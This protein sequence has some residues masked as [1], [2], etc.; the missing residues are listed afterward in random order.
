MAGGG[1]GAGR[2]DGAEGVD[3]CL[4]F[5]ETSRHLNFIL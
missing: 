4:L 5:I 1:G 2:A 3:F